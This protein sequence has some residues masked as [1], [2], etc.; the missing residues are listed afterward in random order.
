MK[1]PINMFC[2][3]IIGR[4]TLPPSPLRAVAIT[5]FR[6]AAR[7]CPHEW[8]TRVAVRAN[9]HGRRVSKSDSAA[10]VYR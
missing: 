3:A 1:P 6:Q 4:Y 9:R 8:S 10:V 7:I 5:T 2:N